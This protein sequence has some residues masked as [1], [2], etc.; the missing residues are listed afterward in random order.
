MG[1]ADAADAAAGAPAFPAAVGDAGGGRARAGVIPATE[2]SPT[3][4]APMAAPRRTER[5]DIRG[6]R[7]S[8]AVA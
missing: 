2:A 4:P 7:S 5:R 6:D 8:R 3:A 1:L